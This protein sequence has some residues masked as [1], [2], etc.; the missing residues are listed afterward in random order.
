MAEPKHNKGK[1]KQDYG[2]PDN[3]LAAVRGRFGQLETDLAASH[4]NAVC[5]FYFTKEDDAL[6]QEWGTFGGWNWCNPPFGHIS[7][8]V[9]KA[10]KSTLSEEYES[11][12]LMLLPAGVGSNWWKAW[13]HGK[14]KVHL[15]NG[16][17][18]F[19]GA[20]DF[21]PKDCVLLE[22]QSGCW[23]NDYQVWTWPTS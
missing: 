1:S 14:C 16:R 4:E 22:Y 19:K 12:T 7:P 9:E 21:Y 8:W 11:K 5:R 18:F 17:L 6:T 15:L 20:I 13:V 23:A 10:Y 3:F 2:T